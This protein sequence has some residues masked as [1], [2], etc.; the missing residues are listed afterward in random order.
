MVPLAFAT[1]TTCGSGADSHG[2]AQK[3][4][5]MSEVLLSQFRAPLPLASRKEAQINNGSR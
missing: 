2:T 3:A 5:S 1:W 4:T